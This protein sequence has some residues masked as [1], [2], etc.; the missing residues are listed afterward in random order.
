MSDSEN[1]FLPNR[2]FTY[3]NENTTFSARGPNI[4]ATNV[5]GLS[6]RNNVL[7]STMNMSR[8]FDKKVRMEPRMDHYTNYYRREVS[9]TTSL[10]S[11]SDFRQPSYY[12]SRYPRAMSSQRSMFNGRSGSP[13]SVRS[14]DTTTS[15]SAADIALAFKN[16]N[17]NKYDKRIIKDAYNKFMRRGIRKKIEKRRKLKLYVKGYRR[18]SGYDSGELGSDSSI[19]S[20]DCRSTR[21][22][23]YNNNASSCRS[24]RTNITD[25]QKTIRENS[26]YKDCTDSFKQNIFMNKLHVRS[27]NRDR[28]IPNE[29]QNCHLPSTHFVSHHNINK[30]HS[31][32]PIMQKDRF[33]SAGLL[34]SQRFHSTVTSTNNITE[35]SKLRTKLPTNTTE[36]T[37]S[38]NNEIFSEITTRGKTVCNTEKICDKEM[39]EQRKR[40]IDIND[41]QTSTSKRNKISSSSQTTS[42][43]EHKQQNQESKK[44]E[45]IMNNKTNDFEF[46]K[47]QFPIRKF[48]Q[49][50]VKEVLL[51]KSA[52]TLSQKQVQPS[53]SMKNVEEESK[54]QAYENSKSKLS[55]HTEDVSMRPSFIKRKLYS[56]KHDLM[57]SKNVSTDN[58][59]ANSPQGNVYSATQKEKHKTRKLV[60]NQSCLNRNVLQEDKNL[61]DLIHKI[62][63]PDRMNITNV[64]NKTNIIT[65]KNH[66]FDEDKWDVT[67]IISTCNDDD[68][69]D[70][71]TDEE[72]MKKDSVLKTKKNESKREIKDKHAIKECKIVIQNLQK[73]N[74]PSYPQKK[75]DTNKNNGN[76]TD[77]KD[78]TRNKIYKCVKSFWDTDFESDSENHKPKSNSQENNISAK[79]NLKKI[80]NPTEVNNVLKVNNHMEKSVLSNK[81]FNRT[82][83]SPKQMKHCIEPVVSKP[84]QVTKET[85]KSKMSELKQKKNDRLDKKNALDTNKAK[86][87]KKITLEI[88][89]SSNDSP[90]NKTIKNRNNKVYPETTLNTINSSLNSTSENIITKSSLRT[91]KTRITKNI[92]PE[93]INETS[94]KT[95]QN[96][97]CETTFRTLRTRRI[98]LSICTF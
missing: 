40:R 88:N 63:P 93:N 38:D 33:K 20:D 69:S 9:P 31:Q 95:Q 14:I 77:Q 19:S 66:L 74:K 5:T 23:S 62:V 25:I 16:I 94:K 96:I 1:D 15:V 39:L 98:N 26:M 27:G 91:R 92:M 90:G 32:G 59:V 7:T 78:L 12:Q 6:F 48:N 11:V 64:T 60:T 2:L 83:Q 61:L 76:K 8:P 44:I 73:I 18:R 10:R 80:N 86:S 56:Q 51:A 4:N 52:Q 82:R 58:L 3:Q 13:M 46:V 71:Y 43:I 81:S 55:Q 41:V 65:N 42:Q 70:T 30:E 67:S 35:D 24:I 84:K 53:H 49:G 97:D 54:D 34:P 89:S 72:I 17:F 75:T 37:D 57:E 45:V 68:V 85:K 28:P 21:T 29:V 36:E 47:P 50:K 22:I 79:I 87:S